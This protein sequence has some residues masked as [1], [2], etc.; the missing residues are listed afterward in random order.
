M[1]SH[2]PQI[3]GCILILYSAKNLQI[4]FAFSTDENTATLECIAINVGYI[5][6]SQLCGR[7]LIVRTVEVGF[8]AIMV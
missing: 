5:T 6:V 8:G 2:F 1:T 4:W 7:T 3:T